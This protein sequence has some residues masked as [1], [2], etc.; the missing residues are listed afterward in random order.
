[1]EIITKIRRDRVS[2]E[3]L[4]TPTHIVGKIRLTLCGR[5]LKGVTWS[6]QGTLEKVDCADCLTAHATGRQRAW[7]SSR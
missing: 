7:K 2:H 4:H 3:R 6:R 5:H 1:M